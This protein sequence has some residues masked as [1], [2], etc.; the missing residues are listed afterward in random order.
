MLPRRVTRSAAKEAENMVNQTA[1]QSVASMFVRPTKRS[2][3]ELDDEAAPVKLQN[4]LKR[5]RNDNAIPENQT[6]SSS[7]V[8]NSASTQSYAED[9]AIAAARGRGRRKAATPKQKREAASSGHEQTKVAPP[10]TAAKGRGKKAQ[11]ENEKPQDIE[12]KSIVPLLFLYIFPS[13]YPLLTIIV[14]FLEESMPVEKAKKGKGKRAQ[15][16][17]D[18][19][20]VHA[21][22]A[23]PETLAKQARVALSKNPAKGHGKN[24]FDMEELE[25]IEPEGNSLLIYLFPCLFLDISITN[26]HCFSRRR[27]S[28]TP[29]DP[30][31]GTWEES[32]I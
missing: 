13:R 8:Q 26:N 22:A 7:M 21:E 17:D 28:H 25:A 23:L 20:P 2:M 10:K 9:V 12:P 6:Q 27:Q 1:H 14:C 4:E 16:V 3:A 15:A 29:K 24:Q 19:P 30:G 31:Q 5:A 11:F 18:A 32:S